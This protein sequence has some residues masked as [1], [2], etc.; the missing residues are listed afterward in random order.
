M[1]IVLKN[2]N[3]GFST[4]LGAILIGD[5]SLTVQ[6]GDGAKFPA[7]GQ[8]RVVLWGQ[9]YSV[10]ADDPNREIITMELSS[11]DIFTIT[12]AQESTVAK[13]WADGDN[14]A[15]TITAGKIIEI[16]TEITNNIDQGV[17]TTDSPTFISISTT[18][19]N[20]TSTFAGEIA[21]NSITCDNVDIR[22]NIQSV[23]AGRGLVLGGI[24]SEER[25][26]GK[27]CRSR[28]SPYH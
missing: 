21:V 13:A 15:H 14:I 19:T 23:A 11:G 5:T 4:L 9:G 7:S 12:R 16:E 20:A 2:K 18:D 22:V 8:F 25:R 17:K 27:E 28:W 26:V 10:P 6:S 3:F 24:R 1:S